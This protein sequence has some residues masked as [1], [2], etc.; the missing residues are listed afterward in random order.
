MKAGM[1]WKQEGDLK[2][3]GFQLTPT[4]FI[5]LMQLFYGYIKYTYYRHSPVLQ[6]R[7]SENVNNKSET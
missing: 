3:D 5:A 1:C 6:T 4:I 7:K 2:G